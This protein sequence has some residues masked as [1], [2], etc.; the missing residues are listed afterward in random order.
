VGVENDKDEK[1]KLIGTIVP[2]DDLSY[3]PAAGWGN[4]HPLWMFGVADQ[5]DRKLAIQSVFRYY[6]I[7]LPVDFVKI[8]GFDTE[9]R[10][11]LEYLDEQV[12]TLTLNGATKPRPPVVYGTYCAAHGARL[13]NEPADVTYPA[14]SKVD[15]AFTFDAARGL[16]MFQ[17]PVYRNTDTAKVDHAEATIY[18][19]TACLVRR[20]WNRAYQRVIVERQIGEFETETQWIRHDELYHTYIDAELQNPV[21]VNN[22]I[23]DILDAAEAEY[24]QEYPQTVTYV[25][26][27][28]IPLDGAIRQATFRVGLSGCTSIYSRNTEQLDRVPSYKERRLVEN[29][30]EQQSAHERH[31]AALRAMEKPHRALWV[32]DTA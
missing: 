29:Q 4:E 17:E 26:L 22:K 19:R 14:G 30:A 15:H 9:D 1:G 25:G 21:P 27:K 20:P 13:T 23:F 2:V 8:M 12:E 16:V 10:P 18:L 31:M 5:D 3:K 11:Y 7:K 28:L 6:R 32:G 24:R